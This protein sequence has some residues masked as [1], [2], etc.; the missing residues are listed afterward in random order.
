MSAAEGVI[1]HFA[2]APD[3][4]GFLVGVSA[5]YFWTIVATA[6]VSLLDSGAIQLTELDVP[7]GS[8]F[9]ALVYLLQQRG[10]LGSTFAPAVNVCSVVVFALT[11]FPSNGRRGPPLTSHVDL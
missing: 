6:K 1:R 3:G 5:S 11:L 10:Y 9:K 7:A 4:S 8:K 2:A